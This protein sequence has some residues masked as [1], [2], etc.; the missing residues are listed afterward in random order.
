MQGYLL[1]RRVAAK[2][3]IAI[4]AASMIIPPS[5]SQG[6][7][8]IGGGQLHYWTLAYPSAP[9]PTRPIGSSVWPA[10]GVA[11]VIAV[12]TPAISICSAPARPYPEVSV[13][14][15]RLA[16]PLLPIEVTGPT[17]PWDTL[18]SLTVGNGGA[19]PMD[20]EAALVSNVTAPFRAE[21]L[22]SSWLP[23]SL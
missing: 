17:P 19:A 4:N 18:S 16:K 23:S 15:V 6:I 7:D 1:Y 5:E 3:A 12:L 11:S 21:A 10:C 8:V 2:P 20:A 9:S 14:I 13:V 22:R